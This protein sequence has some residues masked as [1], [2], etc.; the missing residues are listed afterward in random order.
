M[1]YNQRGVFV[2]HRLALGA[3]PAYKP[4]S[5][6]TSSSRVTHYSDL[7]RRRTQ[8]FTMRKALKRF[9][10]SRKAPRRVGPTIPRFMASVANVHREFLSLD[11]GS[12]SANSSGIV[13]FVYEINC[14][15][16][17]FSAWA[18]IW[19]EWQ[20]RSLEVTITL[21]QTLPTTLAVCYDPDDHTSPISYV[22]AAQSY[23]QH[24]LIKCNNTQSRPQ[25]FRCKF[26]KG[27]QSVPN[28]SI[29]WESTSNPVWPG[30]L[31][32]AGKSFGA[33]QSVCYLSLRYGIAFRTRRS[34][35]Q[36]VELSME[37]KPTPSASPAP[38]M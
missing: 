23:K 11:T 12:I 14:A 28:S 9:R 18:T 5:H 21:L 7:N 1:S 27:A 19:D 16:N 25:I 2:P 13:T 4:F 30:S 35:T 37:P 29:M 17:Q 24:L 34:D 8:E 31:K 22:A 38:S 20:L 3:Q 26:V 33:G 36:V 15:S 32:F 10:K 6:F